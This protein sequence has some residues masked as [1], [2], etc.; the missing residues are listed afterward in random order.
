MK[1]YVRSF[2]ILI[3]L[4]L[5]GLTSAQ[6]YKQGGNSNMENINQTITLINQAKYDAALKLIYSVKVPSNKEERALYYLAKIKALEST[7]Y[8]ANKLVESETDPTKFTNEQKQN[9]LKQSYKDLWNLRS[10]LINMP[11]Q[12][13]KKYLG[14]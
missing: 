2:F 12:E 10:A 6:N 1:Y 14:F 3:C 8:R 4:L 5:S 13:N 7:P 11:Y 9:A